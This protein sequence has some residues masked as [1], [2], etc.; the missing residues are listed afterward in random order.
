MEGENLINRFKSAGQYKVSF[1]G[2]DLS[3]GVY[4]YEMVAG[5]YRAVKKMMLVK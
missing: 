3:S 5:N 4:I 2:D 1:N